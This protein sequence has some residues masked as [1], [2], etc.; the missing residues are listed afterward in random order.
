MCSGIAEQPAQFPPLAP[1][2][3]SFHKGRSLPPKSARGAGRLSAVLPL[4]T[5]H[6]PAARMPRLS[7]GGSDLLGDTW[8]FS[9]PPRFPQVVAVEKP[10][11]PSDE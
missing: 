1:V 2:P 8:L 4:R 3:T 7:P 11:D 6:A 5:S 9:L 10:E